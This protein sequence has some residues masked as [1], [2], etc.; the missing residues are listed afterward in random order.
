MELNR[1]FLKLF[2]TLLV[3][4]G[5]FILFTTFS[6]CK[7]IQN[8]S[9]SVDNYKEVIV[10]R[11][12][13]I[14]EI[15]DSIYEKLVYRHDTVYLYKYKEKMIYKDRVINTSDTIFS[16]V[17]KIENET[18]IKKEVPNWCTNLIIVLL[19]IIVILT[20]ILKIR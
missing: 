13:T 17:I 3:V 15:R 5:I 1:A 10:Y 19:I 18:I 4:S 7:T 16:E 2:K 11:D 6:S 8:N 20:F 9:S 12:S 14:H